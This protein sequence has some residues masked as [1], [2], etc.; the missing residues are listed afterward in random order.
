MKLQINKVLVGTQDEELKGEKGVPLTV[1]LIC[2]NSLIIP[3]QGETDKD[4]WERYELYKKLKSADRDVD[5]KTEELS[6][7]KRCVGKTQ[8]T[9]VMGQIWDEIEGEN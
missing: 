3:Q 6:L 5:L 8:P 7:L 1:K 4:K 2:I 9:L